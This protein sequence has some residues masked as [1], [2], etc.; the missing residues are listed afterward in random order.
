MSRSFNNIDD[1]FDNLLTEAN[2]FGIDFNKIPNLKKKIYELLNK[3]YKS[4]S[5]GYSYCFKRISDED[6]E[7]GSWRKIGT[8]KR[9]VAIRLA[10]WGGPKYIT[11]IFNVHTN[12]NV[13]LER[14]IHVFLGEWRKHRIN[15]KNSEKKEIEWFFVPENININLQ[16]FIINISSLLNKYSQKYYSD[17]QIDNK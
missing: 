1:L 15:L 11:E 17:K 14:L 10:E 2:N 13:L 12:F 7:T 3:N 6:S 9:S 5:P 4:E 16:K 8:T